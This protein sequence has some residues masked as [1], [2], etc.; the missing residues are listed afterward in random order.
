MTFGDS[1]KTCLAKIMLPLKGRASRSEFWY[2]ALFGFLAIMAFLIVVFGV[3]AAVGLSI[4]P[5]NPD[6]GAF[7]VV[8]F[9]LFFLV[10]LVA[11]VFFMAISLGMVAATVRRLHDRNMSGWWYVGYIVASVIPFVNL[12]ALVALIVILC[13]KG[14]NGH[15]NYGPDPLNSGD[16]SVFA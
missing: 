15:N 7:G 10:Y 14:T 11:I 1:I 9:I 2:F 5:A 3:I 8:G 4:D 12:I 13:L 6:F 16:S